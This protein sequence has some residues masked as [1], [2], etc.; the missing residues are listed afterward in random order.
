MLTIYAYCVRSQRQGK[1]KKRFEAMK[2]FKI[3][4]QISALTSTRFG[5]LK[6]N[7]VHDVARNTENHPTKSGN[8]IRGGKG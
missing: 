7:L 4:S 6:T 8:K 5:N 2:E 1:T 3:C